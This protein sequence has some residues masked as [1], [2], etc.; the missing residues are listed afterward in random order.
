MVQQLSPKTFNLLGDYV[1]NHIYEQHYLK[2]R[3]KKEEGTQE[4]EKGRKVKVTRTQETNPGIG[5]IL[6][7]LLKS[8]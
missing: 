1:F 3:K 7:I 2:K 6:V 8:R 5:P 4:E